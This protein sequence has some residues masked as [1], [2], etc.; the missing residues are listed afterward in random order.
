MRAISHDWATV[1]AMLRPAADEVHVW[2]LRWTAPAEAAA[3]SRHLSQEECD[4][5][6]P[7]A[8][9]E[10]REEFIVARALLRL[11]LGE[12][13]GLEPCRVQFSQTSRGKPRLADSAPS[14]FPLTSRIR[15]AWRCSP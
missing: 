1:P 9:R 6:E 10:R 4:R 3:L 13:L 8:M 11:L 15:T 14:P 2:S 7:F 5:A 12:C